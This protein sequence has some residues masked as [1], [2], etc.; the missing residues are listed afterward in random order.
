MCCALV[1]ITDDR[2]S[3]GVSISFAS[4]SLRGGTLERVRLGIRVSEV[5]YEV[6]VPRRQ[7]KSSATYGLECAPT[8][9]E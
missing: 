5:S 6:T 8:H 7:T 3:G 2:A 1:S 9:L 4:V